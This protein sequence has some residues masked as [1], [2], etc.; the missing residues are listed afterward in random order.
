M[1]LI[2]T[3]STRYTKNG[4]IGEIMNKYLACKIGL[5][6]EKL[7]NNKDSIL[8]YQTYIYI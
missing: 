7:Q 6:K 5:L 2:R 1:V 4:Y 8:F 3:E